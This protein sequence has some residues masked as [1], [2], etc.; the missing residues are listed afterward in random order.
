VQT[1]CSLGTFYLSFGRTIGISSTTY[2]FLFFVSVLAT[3][4]VGF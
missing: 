2:N 1:T 3:T 4:V